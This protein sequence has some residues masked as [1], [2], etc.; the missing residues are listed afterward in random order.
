[1]PIGGA[2]GQPQIEGMQMC[3]VIESDM[4]KDAVGPILPEERGV[5]DPRHLF[6]LAAE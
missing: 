1:M 6:L 3:S 4:K 2:P 5:P